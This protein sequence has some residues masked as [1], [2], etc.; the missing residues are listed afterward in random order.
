MW[1]FMKPEVYASPVS[2][3]EELLN[4][5]QFATEKVREKLWHKVTVWAIQK[6]ARAP[7]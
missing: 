1:V 5:I 4:R 6:R 7:A 3:E 2:S